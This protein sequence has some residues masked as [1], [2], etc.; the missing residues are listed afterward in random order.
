[1]ASPE[2]IPLPR[3]EFRADMPSLW[4]MLRYAVR[5]NAAA[6]PQA[7][8]TQKAVQL[9]GPSAPLLVSDPA[10]IRDVLTDR[11]GRFD[12]DILL[13]RLFRRA[14][15]RGLAA[16]EGQAWQ[17]QRRAATPLFQ[18]Q[19]VE[20][21]STAFAKIADRAIE[22]W[23]VG[24][25]IKLDPY[26]ARTIAEVVFSI[27]VDAEGSIDTEAVA[28]SVPSYVQK[29][30]GFGL[31]DLLPLSERWHDHIVGVDRNLA[32]RHI[33]SQAMA[34]AARDHAKPERDD[35]VTRLNGIGP[36]A[37]NISGLIPAAM[38]TTSAA[39]GWVLYVLA[40][41]PDWQAKVAAE[42]REAG[43]DARLETLPITR[44]VVQEVL[45]LYPPTPMTARSVTKDCAL[46]E[47]R[48]KRG[49]RLLLHLYA[50]H[51]R[52]DTWRDPDTFDPDRFLSGDAPA[53]AWMPF[54][55]GPRVCIAAQFALTE[56]VIIAARIMAGLELAPV[57]PE[58]ELTLQISTRSLTGLNV[59]AR[60]RG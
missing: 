29:I 51:R 2:P 11:Q 37:D 20:A 38:E 13:R 45:R 14:W 35:F 52:P 18:P 34:L 6:I 25:P 36:I 7:I 8:F 10:L 46:G 53:H 58:P 57:G 31:S 42:A 4:D 23:P 59:V 5:D 30:A 19:A 39:L 44:A 56:L 43:T 33:R 21:H 41:R 16:A 17:D 24:E 15:G 47:F 32:I 26:A 12:R 49:Q 54:G 22:T 27:L 60:R 55:A 9:P 40:I 1:M 3:Y 28:R 50:M 48:V